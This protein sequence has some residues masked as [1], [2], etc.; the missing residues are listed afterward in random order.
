MMANEGGKVHLKCVLYTTL[1]FIDTR[2]LQLL[3]RDMGERWQG[4]ES[5]KRKK[6]RKKYGE[7]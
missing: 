2:L 5:T 4:D 7:G 3:E 1:S 6:E